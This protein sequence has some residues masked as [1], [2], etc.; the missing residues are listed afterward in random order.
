MITIVVFHEVYLA[1]IF[2]LCLNVD[3]KF[4]IEDK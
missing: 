2:N 4:S 1:S 3:N